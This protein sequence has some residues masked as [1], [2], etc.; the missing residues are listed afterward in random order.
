[1]G[2]QRR[3]PVVLSVPDR[4]R[5]ADLILKKYW[6]QVPNGQIFIMDTDGMFYMAVKVKGEL[7]RVSLERME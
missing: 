5:G 2:D 4:A 3:V 7:Y 1:M 6:G